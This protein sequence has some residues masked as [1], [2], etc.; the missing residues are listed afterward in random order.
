MV[1]L[2]AAEARRAAPASRARPRRPD[3]AQGAR[4]P[5]RNLRLSA[6]VA[7]V[8]GLA[9]LG[10]S[11]PRFVAAGIVLPHDEI[12]PRLG[13]GEEV[14]APE[15]SLAIEAH[16]AAIAWH[17]SARLHQRLGQL[18]FALAR[19]VP[20]ADRRALAL[21]TAVEAHEA[22]LARNPTLPFSAL[23]IAL[24]RLELSGPGPAFAAA[25]ARSVRV[26][27][28][29]PDLMFARVGI[30]LRAW[31]RL[32]APTRDLVVAQVR[33]AAELD[34]KRLANAVGGA[35][36]QALVRRLLVERPD[37]LAALERAQKRADRPR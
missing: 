6:V 27:P 32:D 26:A 35:S 17:D 16:E 30:G 18:R 22:A 14:A 37:L 15:L 7:L 23:Q 28:V 9:L 25:F 29:A 21:E 2:D 11:A 10:L 13:R 1:P 19:R 12:V 20:Q 5:R 36:R 31:P 34:P 24:A 33:S 3:G 4:A 8:A